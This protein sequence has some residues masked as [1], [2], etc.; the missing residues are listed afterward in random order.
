AAIAATAAEGGDAADQSLWNL[1]VPV[2]GGADHH[3]VG[4]VGFLEQML[5]LEIAAAGRD[6]LLEPGLV[7][8]PVPVAH[9]LERHLFLLGI[10]LEE[11]H[12]NRPVAI[13]LV[14]AALPAKDVGDRS[15]PRLSQ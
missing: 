5:V 15:V 6:G 1:L 4:A 2:A 12:G 14:P 9:G 11:V 7:R 10:K 8:P 3:P 13:F